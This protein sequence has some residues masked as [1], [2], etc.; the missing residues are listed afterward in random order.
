MNRF[1]NGVTLA[2]RLMEQ[3]ADRCEIGIAEPNVL[4]HDSSDY[5]CQLQ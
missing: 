5:S 2:A 1:Q 3:E 4:S